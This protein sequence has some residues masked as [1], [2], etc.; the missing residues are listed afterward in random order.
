MKIERLIGCDDTVDNVY[1]EIED[2]LASYIRQHADEI[3]RARIVDGEALSLTTK[4]G[5][6]FEVHLME[7]L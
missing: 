1:G 3:T 2:A 7:V 6:R 4:T 5:R